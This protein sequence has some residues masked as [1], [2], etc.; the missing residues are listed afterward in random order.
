MKLAGKALLSALLVFGLGCGAFAGEL[1]VAAASDLS[2]AAREIIADFEKRT[3]HTV[4][5]TLGSSGNFHAQIKNGAPFDVFLSAD[6]NYVRDLEKAGLAEPDTAS[7]YAIG[8][9]VLWAPRNSRIDIEELG[10]KALLLP[11]VR[12]IAIA[13]P[14]HAPYGRA[15]VSAMESAGVYNAVKGKLVLG[16]NI[17]QTAQFVQSRAADVGI[18]A[19]SVA[20]TDP[21]KAQGKSWQIPLDSYPQM[22]QGAVILK[23]AQ[24]AGHAAA[25]RAFLETLRGPQGRA[26]LQRYGFSL[27]EAG[28]R[29]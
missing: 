29:R 4:K 28:P 9:I 1:V 26:V 19:L 15:A 18:L 8:R 23:Q 7:I 12:K 21:L 16:E 6:M 14:D 25:A 13:N 11:E 24:R 10:M 2:G 22:E 3:G 17:S 5:L 27:P 20:L